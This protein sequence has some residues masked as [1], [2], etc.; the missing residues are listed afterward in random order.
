[1]EIKLQAKYGANSVQSRKEMGTFC[2]AFGVTKI[3]APSA[4]HKRVQKKVNKTCPYRRPPPL[5]PPKPYKKKFGPK[6][7]PKGKGKTPIKKNK[8]VCYKCGKVGNKAFQ[9]KTEQNIN[10]F[11]F[12]RTR[13]LEKTLGFINKRIF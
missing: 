7:T 8:I 1:M 9:C 10:E 5:P 4:V 11:F 13:T 6:T 12:W 2:D 3:E